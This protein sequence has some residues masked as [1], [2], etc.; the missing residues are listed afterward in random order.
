M[1]DLILIGGIMENNNYFKTKSEQDIYK[2]GFYNGAIFG[3]SF[4][5]WWKNG[6][7]YVGSCSQTL[8]EALASLKE[9]IK[10]YS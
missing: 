6:I 8:K 3:I 5:A 10:K 9:D 4:Y 1:S 2:E 7:Q